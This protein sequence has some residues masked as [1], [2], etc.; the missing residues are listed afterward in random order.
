MIIAHG[1]F[2]KNFFPQRPEFKTSDSNV[3]NKRDVRKSNS[4]K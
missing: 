2:R 4:T 1:R 3:K